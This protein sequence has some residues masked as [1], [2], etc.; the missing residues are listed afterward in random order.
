MAGIPGRDLNG[1][2]SAQLNVLNARAFAPSLAPE[3]GRLSLAGLSAWYCAR[4]KP[5]HEHIA[6]ANLRRHLGLEV[7]SPRLRSERATCRG[8]VKRVSEPL[9]PC[10]LFV[11]CALGE[12]MEQVRHT[13]GISSMVSF[14]QRIPEVPEAV[15]E[16]LRGCF[17]GEE[18]LDVE[19]C[20]AP[21]EGVTV[22]GGAFLGMEAVVLRAWPAKRR[23]A[24]LLEILG[25]PARMEVDSHLLELERGCMAG[26]VPGL[27]AVAL[28]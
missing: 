20:P 6:A 2:Q 18:A 10:Y 23:V 16:D 25:Q 21:G 1:V 14:G 13:S 12:Q 9:F 19:T 4:T 27:A 28:A 17:G 3:A 5:K 22:A 24:I 7:F 8:V 11:H 15:L 26:S